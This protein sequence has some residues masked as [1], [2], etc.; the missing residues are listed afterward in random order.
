MNSLKLWG[1]GALVAVV[2]GGAVLASDLPVRRSSAPSGWATFNGL[3][4]VTNVNSMITLSKTGS[5]NCL[6][7]QDNQ[8]GPHV[9]WDAVHGGG[10]MDASYQ[11]V[12]GGVTLINGTVT[13]GNSEWT[14]S[15]VGLNAAAS[16][17]TLG[18]HMLGAGQGFSLNSV[19]LY[20]SSVGGGGAG[21]TIVRVTDGTNTCDTTFLC[22]TTNSTGVKRVNGTG[23]AGNGCLFAASAAITYS[24]TASTCTTTQPTIKNIDFVGTGV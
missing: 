15:S 11:G 17:V 10:T 22:T 13:A 20:V 1:I 21:S 3:P 16:A 24:I 23:T 4:I 18:G 8:D 5:S 9:C 6:G 12:F 14:L 19:T 7:F 2:V